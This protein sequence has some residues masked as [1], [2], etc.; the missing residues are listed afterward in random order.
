[1]R[2]KLLA[3]LCSTAVAFAG[4]A[5][6]REPIPIEALS[7]MPEIQSISMSSDGKRIVA[8][9][10]KQGA[11]DF[12]TS[13]A[14][15]D[16]DD[17]ARPPKVTASGDRMK[18]VTA[19]ALKSS[20]VFVI[21]RQ[22]WT[23]PIGNCGGEG[24]TVGTTRTFVTKAYL[25]DGSQSDFE[26]A[27][28]GR[29]R[30]TG[31][32]DETQRCFEIMG[33]AQLA[34]I[35]PLDAD[36]VVIQQTN[37]ATLRGDYYRYNLKTKKTEL[38]FRATGRS[39]PA[40]LDPRTGEVLVRSDLESVGGSYESRF[41]FRDP[42]TGEFVVH[43]NLNSRIELR[44]QTD[45]VGRDEKTGK[46]YVL[47]DKFSDLVQAWMYDP[48]TRQFDAQ[49]L[50]AHP[51]FSIVNLY[52][53]SR[54]SDFNQV[55]GFAVGGMTL[56][57]TWI[58]PRLSAIQ[59]GLDKAYP[60]E[61]VQI[62]DFTDDRSKVLFSASS[63][64]HP[65]RYFLLED[66]ARAQLLGAS[67][68][69]IDADAIGE[70]RWITY[71]ARDGMRIPA[72]LDL[73]AGWTPEQGPLPAIVHPHGGPRA[74]DFGGWDSSGWV[75]FFTSRGYA[76]LRPQFRGS[77]GLGRKLLIA[78]DAQWGLKMQD[79]KDD[80]AAWLVKEGIADPERIAIMGYSYGGFAAAAATVR[81]NSPYRCAIAGA[82]LTNLARVSTT[83]SDNR[84]ER[85]LVGDSIKGMDPIRHTDKASLPILLFV[86]DRDVRTPSWHAQ[87]FY[88]AVK[89]KVPA[90]FELIPD[91]PHSFPWY[92][93]HFERGMQLMEE[94]LAKDCAMGAARGSATASVSA[95]N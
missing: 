68:S 54:P 37:A 73:P 46:F 86:G 55:L 83:W 8:L 7:R 38:L 30:P 45:F 85:I 77:E 9:I 40:L 81:P 34:N 13:L 72:I 53:G 21:G 79:D 36:H 51:E 44:H 16:L 75:P 61:T 15:W 41:Y 32:S 28:A 22:E 39:T 24:Q 93:R 52:L 94:F 88:N 11:R 56:E 65:T 67:R 31:V 20:H 80:G 4:G 70:Q 91:Q 6:A 47:T 63:H 25:S 58:E 89:D 42:E 33:S 5:S 69:G 19:S 2:L 43:E 17:L 90:R 26:E 59:S 66:G 23:G 35:L 92:P 64:R 49:P 60:D 62:I 27:F 50:V 18:F 3:I 1:M 76:V 57:T 87:D 84:L 82:P 95:S 14:T 48:K 29:N 74:R 12:D 78:G 10:G 71:T